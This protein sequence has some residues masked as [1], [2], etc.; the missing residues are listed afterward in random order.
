MEVL[1]QGTDMS[2][3][4]NG[5]NSWCSYNPNSNCGDEGD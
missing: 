3:L 2:N 5:C 4:N 1:I